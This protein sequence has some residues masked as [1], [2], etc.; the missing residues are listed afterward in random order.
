M[1]TSRT[2]ALAI[3]VAMEN[4]KE[5]QYSVN[6]V[7]WHRYDYANSP[8]CPDFAIFHYRVKPEPVRAWCVAD[9][10]SGTVV[11]CKTSL[12]VAEEVAMRR[13]RL[14]NRDNAFVV[15]ELTG[16]MP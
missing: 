1:K 3:L 15:V 2:A 8:A 13:N 10:I 5:I 16:D 6:G 12:R 4:R 14:A 11:A 9:A 7:V